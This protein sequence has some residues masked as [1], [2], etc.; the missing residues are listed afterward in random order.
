MAARFV[1]PPA[2]YAQYLLAESSV[3]SESHAGLGPSA[4]AGRDGIESR[5][6]RV[7]PTAIAKGT[8]GFTQVLGSGAVAFA[9]QGVADRLERAF[10]GKEL[11]QEEFAGRRISPALAVLAFALLLV[12]VG[13]AVAIVVGLRQHKAGPLK[14]NLIRAVPFA[15]WFVAY[16]L[17]TSATSPTDP[18][19]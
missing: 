5:S 10:P 6:I 16:W 4:Q 8:I 14:G 17:I 12:V 2:S 11:E 15:V 7:H 19:A 18:E 13:L 3:G 1:N 9:Y